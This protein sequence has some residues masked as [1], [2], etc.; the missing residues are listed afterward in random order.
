L[1]HL[2][3]YQRFGVRNSTGPLCTNVIF[4]IRILN[5]GLCKMRIHRAFRNEIIV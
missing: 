5:L 4:A 1:L 2:T 3:K